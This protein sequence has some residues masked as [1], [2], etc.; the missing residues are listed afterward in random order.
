LRNFFPVVFIIIHSFFI[1]RIT[2]TMH[3]IPPRSICLNRWTKPTSFLF[4][5]LRTSRC[6]SRN[7][8]LYFILILWFTFTVWST[9]TTPWFIT[10]RCK[11]DRL[12]LISRLIISYVWQFVHFS[13]IIET[14]VLLII[15]FYLKLF[16]NK[17]Y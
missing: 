6:S 12:S 17:Y 3:L 8:N 2:I 5:L 15:L 1:F 16:K 7:F 11:S 4:L 10:F 9:T 14:H 13:I